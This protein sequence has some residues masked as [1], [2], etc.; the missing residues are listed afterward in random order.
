MHPNTS[1]P[2]F[3]HNQDIMDDLIEQNLK[4]VKENSLQEIDGH[5]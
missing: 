5:A 4:F 1:M 2:T 3:N